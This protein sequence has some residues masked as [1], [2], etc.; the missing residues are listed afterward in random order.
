MPRI[1]V[2]TFI[3]ASPELCFDLARDMK[4]H[5][6]T[7]GG[8]GERVVEI[9]K[10]SDKSSTGVPGDPRVGRGQWLLELG[11]TV[12]FE[13]RH[14]GI[15]QRLTSKIV[16]FDRPREFVDEMQRGAFKSMRHSHRFEPLNGGTKMIDVV[17]FES[18]G[19]IVGR[20]V[21]RIFLTGYLRRFLI[22]RGAAIK[23]I[24]EEVTDP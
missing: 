1:R 21:N 2:E 23:R 22:A 18:P 15:R 7:T 24:A 19:W 12:T 16:G 13:A 20:F 17:D 4:V 9:I 5:E 8:T 6:R 11:D 14:L 10:A 3:E